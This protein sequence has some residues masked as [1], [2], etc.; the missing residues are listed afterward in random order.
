LPDESS[1]LPLLASFFLY[2]HLLEVFLGA[3]H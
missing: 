3:V 2:S 1:H